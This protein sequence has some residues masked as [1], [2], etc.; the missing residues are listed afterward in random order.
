MSL[1][2][3]EIS[4][5]ALRA[6]L[7]AIRQHIGTRPLLAPTV[8]G[9]AYGHGLLQTATAYLEAGA[10]WLCVNALYEARTLRQADIRA[11]IYIMGYIAKEDLHEALSLRCD[12]V[13]YNFETLRHL[14]KITQSSGLK[15]RVHLKLE[16]GNHRQGLAHNDALRMAREIQQ[17]PGVELFGLC[18]HFAN[19]EDTTD[20]HYARAQEARF[21]AFHEALLAE[22][23]S[24]KIRHMAN[25]AATILWPERCLDMVRLGVSGYGMWPSR[26][27]QVSSLLSGQKTLS[28]RPALTWK[29]KIAQIKE[30]PAGSFV[31]YG[32]T[33]KTTHHTRL[34]ILPIGYY[35]G[36]D[37]GLS[38]IAHV[39]IRGQRAPV[40]GRVCMN[41]VMVDITDIP[42]VSLEEE[43]I[44]LGRDE[45]NGEEITAEQ[46]A[47]WAQTIN[48]EITTR[49][50][51]QI[52]RI[53]TT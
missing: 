24:C 43:V 31:G 5:S 29:C 28:L 46:M 14:Q 17:S 8:K 34:A 48:Y 18:S 38:N 53:L 7:R 13:L 3:C 51:D 30:V 44:L 27:T 50:N 2:W 41:I 45:E 21:H 19:I 35:D 49:I 10:D 32:C 15:A 42:A 23:I 22:E 26:E 37:R 47:T 16:T 4:R 36:Y 25:S 40:R 1:T 20:Q 9:N 33:Y 39:L 6:N 11:P 12:L 52:P